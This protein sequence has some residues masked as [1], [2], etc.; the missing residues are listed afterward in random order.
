MSQRGGGVVQLNQSRKMVYPTTR[1]G[2]S[3][4]YRKMEKG[5]E[6]ARDILKKLWG[7]SREALLNIEKNGIRIV[8]CTRCNAGI[9]RS[10][11][12]SSDGKCPECEFDLFEF[13]S[14]GGEL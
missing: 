7:R 14:K 1:E 10:K 11:L 9:N 12:F 4:L 6:Q 13:R 3:D 2:I 5:D 8:G